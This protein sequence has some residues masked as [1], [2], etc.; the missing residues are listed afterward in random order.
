MDEH[1][2]LTADF[3]WQQH[4]I[5]PPGT[6][7]CHGAEGSVRFLIVLWT[8]VLHRASSP[9]PRVGTDFLEMVRSP[10]EC[11]KSPDVIFQIIPRL[12]CICVFLLPLQ[13]AYKSSTICY[14]PEKGTWTELEGEVAEP[15]AGPACST[16]ILPACLPFN[17]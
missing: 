12:D 2:R 7:G 13:G 5:C 9:S 14:S 11:R 6:V 8:A 3:H 4:P 17:K 1:I 16:V 15:L 10:H